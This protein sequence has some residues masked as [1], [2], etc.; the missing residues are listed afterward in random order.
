MAIPFFSPARAD[1]LKG[2]I[3]RGY[4]TVQVLQEP[5][6]IVTFLR[7]SPETGMPEA[8]PG[9]TNVSLVRIGFPDR[10]GDKSRP[11]QGAV[12][13]TVDGELK[14]YAPLPIRPGDAFQWQSHWCT[15]ITVYPERYDV[16]RATFQLDQ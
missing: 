1:R 7:I 12:E 11:N 10:E 8:L 5:V 9:L 15:V 6:P 13:A 16:V 3:Q 4:A 2:V 14:G